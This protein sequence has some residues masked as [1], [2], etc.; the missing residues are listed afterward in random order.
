M[1]TERIFTLNNQKEFA[2]LSGDWNPMH[3]DP[4]YARRLILGKTVVHGIHLLL[5]TLDAALAAQLP[6]IISSID[7][8]FMKPVGVD[9]KVS[10]EWIQNEGRLE[11]NLFTNSG[12]ILTGKVEFDCWKPTFSTISQAPLSQNECVELTAQE[13]TP[14]CKE[15]EVLCLDAALCTVLFPQLLKKLPSTQVAALI[16][17]SQIIGMRCPGQHSIYAGLKL[18]CPKEPKDSKRFRFQLERFDDRFSFTSIKFFSPLLE[19]TLSAFLRPR[20]TVQE[21]FAKLKTL[22]NSNEFRERRALVLGG[23]RGLGEVA[24]KLL[25]AG[26]ADVRITYHNGEKEALAICNEIKAK[27]GKCSHHQC[28]VLSPDEGLGNMDFGR[29]T[30]TDVCYFP[31]PPIFVGHEGRYSKK[32]FDEFCDYYVSGF[33][34]V[35]KL[36]DYSKATL[37]V[38]YPSTVAVTEP[39]LDMLEYASAKAAGEKLCESL[40]RNFPNLRI[41][42]PR[43]PRLET[44]QTASLYP[45]TNHAPAPMVLAELRQLIP[46]K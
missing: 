33:M 7:V 13:L 22:V 12:T 36:L 2:K 31:T 9:E 10:A 30:P 37:N 44:D 17:S 15:E 29:W 3:T 40:N 43:F 8:R 14:D 32:I 42:S 34:S 21:S 46:S 23:S 5:W 35:L 4:Q 39:P 19:G 41:I 25:A 24:A 16:R 1:Y 26:G 18:K 28:N 11:F 45:V 20:P 38:L 27:K 6:S